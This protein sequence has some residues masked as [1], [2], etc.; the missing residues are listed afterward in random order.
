MS[1]PDRPALAALATLI[2]IQLVMLASLFAKTPPHPPAAI[3]LFG[4]APFVAVSISVA[5]AA[6]IVG[7]LGT[8]V[9]RGLSVLAML[10]ALVSFG[11]H[12]FLDAQIGLT[13]P[14]VAVSQIAVAAIV[15]QMFAHGRSSHSA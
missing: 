3:P 6:M 4:M 2:V 11:P 10:C 15:W 14:A 8:R 9:G 1:T 13:W 12:K 5:L 7:P